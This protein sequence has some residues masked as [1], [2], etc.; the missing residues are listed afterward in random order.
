MLSGHISLIWCK[1]KKVF[2][3]CPILMELC[4][5]K[6]EKRPLY[7]PGRADRQ[8]V[9]PERSMRFFVMRPNTEKQKEGGKCLLFAEFSIT[10][11]HKL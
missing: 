4:D 3:N 8:G 5:D 11:H 2:V 10:L 7:P 6:T 1:S 9:H